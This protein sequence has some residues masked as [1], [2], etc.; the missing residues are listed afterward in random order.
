[1]PN[2]EISKTDKRNIKRIPFGPI[3]VGLF[4]YFVGSFL[5]KKIF[6]FHI[7]QYQLAGKRLTPEETFNNVLDIS[8]S[9]IIQAFELIGLFIVPLTAG[10]VCAKLT[11]KNIRKQSLVLAIL[12]FV[13]EIVGS[14]SKGYTAFF[15]IELLDLIY[16][17]ISFIMI[18]VG[19][20]VYN[21]TSNQKPDS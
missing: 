21:K 4:I 20:F 12:I 3:I 9:P 17:T 5:F 18:L 8:N 19:A 7:Y 15:K 2:K 13:V 1:M 16:T 10:Y 11:N 14:T 6:Q